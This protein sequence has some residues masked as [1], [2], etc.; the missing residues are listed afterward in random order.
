MGSVM[1]I[2]IITIGNELLSGFTIDRNSAWIGQRLLE[3]GLKVHVKKTIADDADMITKSLD[4]LSKDC[5]Y[6]I[7][8]GGL[9]P[10]LDDITVKTLYEYFDDSPVF[11]E[12]YWKELEKRFQS[13][14]MKVP[15]LNRNQAHA[16]D[17]V[18][19]IDN[20]FGTARGMHFEKDGSNYF[21][22]P[23]V[24]KEMEGMI[25][26][27]ILPYLEEKLTSKVHCETI[28]TTGLPESILQEKIVDLIESN[29]NC[30]VAF[31]PHRMLGVDIRLTTSNHKSLLDLKDQIVNRISKY[32]Y[33][34][35]ND[36]IEE[37]VADKLKEQNLTVATAES[38]TA[39]MLSAKLTN[40]SGSSQYFNGGV[41][42]YNNAL[43]R[44]IVGVDGDLLDKYGA[45][46]EEVASELASK[47]AKKLKS[48]IGIGIT[49]IAGPKGG[50]EKKPVGLTF[51]GIF[52]KNNVYIK[53]Y[54]LT[55]NR[56]INRQLTVVLCLNELR[57]LLEKN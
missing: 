5:N 38:C 54:N 21:A 13:I 23:G 34:F 25:L 6:I 47:I 43:K 15:T 10:T 48:D 31:L 11:D 2:G 45:V 8:T 27:Y 30:D 14:N 44:D 39:G 19:M 4:E 55:P 29:K 24:P 20:S 35:N 41:A 18:K 50:T 16:G 22:L 51:V 26:S 42:C 40:L 53:Q 56:K 3:I 49:G 33:G 52:Y 9:G 17:K 37:I 28:R 46:S 12:E 32:V 36:R 1:K 7:I 57:K